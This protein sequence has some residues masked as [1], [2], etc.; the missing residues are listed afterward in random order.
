MPFALDADPS[1]TEISDA[2][3]YLLAN[4]TVGNSID[5]T[6]GQ[7]LAPGGQVLGYIYQYIAVKYADDQFG[8][9]FSN[10]PTNKAYYGINNSNSASESSNPADLSLIHI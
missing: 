2:I 10:S 6:T 8:T 4:L 7:I 3:N 5:P 9:G 1:Q